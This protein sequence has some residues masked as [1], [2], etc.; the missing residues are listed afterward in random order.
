MFAARIWGVL[1]KK[2]GEMNRASG[3]LLTEI[4]VLQAVSRSQRPVDL[5]GEFDHFKSYTIAA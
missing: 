2:P 3:L 5:A 4:I 1:P